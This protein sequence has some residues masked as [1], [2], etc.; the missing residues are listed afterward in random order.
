[1]D[2]TWTAGDEVCIHHHV[3]QSPIA[4]E[5]VIKMELDDRLFLLVCKPMIAR[6]FGV[7]LVSFAIAAS[8]FVESATVDFSPPKDV[9]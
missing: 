3:S 1:M 9:S 5:R 2:C 4:I 7:V 6:D 8:P